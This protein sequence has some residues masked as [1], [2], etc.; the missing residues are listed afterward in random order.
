MRAPSYRGHGSDSCAGESNHTID[1]KSFPKKEQSLLVRLL[2]A[3]I[4]DTRYI[5]SSHG[6]LGAF[7]T[8]TALSNVAHMPPPAHRRSPRARASLPPAST[9]PAVPVRALL[10]AWLMVSFSSVQHAASCKLVLSTCVRIA[11]ATASMAP[12]VPARVVFSALLMVRFSGVQHAPSYRPALP[13][14]AR[15]AAATASTAPRSPRAGRVLGVVVSQASQCG[16]IQVASRASTSSSSVD[17]QMTTA[18]PRCFQKLP[19]QE[20]DFIVQRWMFSKL[21]SSKCW[22]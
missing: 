13:A 19:D 1:R 6:I 21:R 9:A 12:A 8:C 11:A 17:A 7:F 10:P 2:Q 15:I 20:Q 22:C 4:P 3:I 5:P 14:C 16:Q 18:S